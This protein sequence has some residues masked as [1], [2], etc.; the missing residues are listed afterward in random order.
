MELYAI[1]G[2][3]KETASAGPF[4]FAVRAGA[5][6]A[7]DS[8]NRRS[9]ACIRLVRAG[10]SGQS[11]ARTAPA[12]NARP[13]ARAPARDTRELG[14]R[15]GQPGG[16]TDGTEWNETQWRNDM[17][18]V[19]GQGFRRAG[20]RP[21]SSPRTTRQRRL[22]GSGAC[23][24]SCPLLSVIAERL[25]FVMPGLV[26]LLSGLDFA[27]GAHGLDSSRFRRAR[28][29]RDS[30][31]RLVCRP[32]SS[33]CPDSFRASTSASA[34]APTEM[35]GTSPGMTR[36][37]RNANANRCRNRPSDDGR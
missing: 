10:A 30:D 15:S 19:D 33:S 8:A 21:L 3:R 23:S 13:R 9:A 37:G 17:Q 29:N 7:P 31:R 5:K 25:P 14:F 32:P 6:K 26:P 16:G 1:L 2:R 12:R 24:V 28:P 4:R 11:G 35:P 22:G 36:R 20:T 27:D 18:D 34:M